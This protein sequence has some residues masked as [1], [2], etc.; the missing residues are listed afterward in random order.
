MAATAPCCLTVEAVHHLAFP[1]RR[2]SA[3]SLRQLADELMR[4]SNLA[5]DCSEQLKA[6]QDYE[7]GLNEDA[8]PR[9]ALENR[10]HASNSSPNEADMPPQS[11]LQLRHVDAPSMP[12][13]CTRGARCRVLACL[14]SDCVQRGGSVSALDAAEH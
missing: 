3:E 2:E 1:D 6:S 13:E 7:N 10:S 11:L 12:R 9:V 4:L 14:A 8:V 5:R